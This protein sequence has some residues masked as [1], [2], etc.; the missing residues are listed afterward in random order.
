ETEA[1]GSSL[2]IFYIPE[3][4]SIYKDR[5]E[6]FKEKQ[7]YSDAD[8]DPTQA[9]RILESFCQKEKIEFINPAATFSSEANKYAG[10]GKWLYYKEGHWT[11]EGNKL[12]AEILFDYFQKK[13]FQFQ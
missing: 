8:Y 13:K 9:G 10:E 4:N 5:W 6:E 1:Q 3:N 7:F 2:L 11:P 12:T